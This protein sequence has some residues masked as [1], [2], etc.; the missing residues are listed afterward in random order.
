[1]R[2]IFEGVETRSCRRKGRIARGLLTLLTDVKDLPRGQLGSS[3]LFV[4]ISK[5]STYMLL[6]TS[7]T[8]TNLN[9]PTRLCLRSEYIANNQAHSYLAVVG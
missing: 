9:K 8:T 6:S 1:M 3:H 5:H 4:G 2:L 7:H